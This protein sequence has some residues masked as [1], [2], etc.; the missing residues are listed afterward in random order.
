[1]R[2][3]AVCC[4]DTPTAILRIPGIDLNA[5]LVEGID[6]ESLKKGIGHYPDSADPWDD[7]GTVGL[8]GHRTTY[9]AP[10]WDLQKLHPGDEIRLATEAGAFDYVV[11]RTRVV[12]PSATEV[13]DPT[14]KPTLVLTTCTPR[15]SAAQRLI[16]FAE[17]VDAA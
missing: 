15:F 5:V 4:R 11:T 16:V 17:R 8:A 7:G 12:L 9:G 3:R 6:T 10:F 13:L 1:M 14:R 2:R